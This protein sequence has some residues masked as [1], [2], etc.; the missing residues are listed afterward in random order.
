MLATSSLLRSPRRSIII[1][2]LCSL[3][4]WLLSSH[5]KGPS[6]HA[7]RLSA[8]EGHIYTSE[9]VTQLCAAH[10]F[11]PA[12]VFATSGSSGQQNPQK[13][14]VY[15]L[16][17]LS[18]E[19]DWL[20]IRLN[21]LYPYVDYF[22][23]LE[24][25]HTSTGQPKPLHLRENWSR[26]E[27]FHRKLIYVAVEGDSSS[28]RG[29]WDTEN[30]FRD[31]LLYETMERVRGKEKEFRY[32]D[33]LIV[34][35][36]DELPRPETVKLLRYCDFPD[37]LTLRSHFYS[38]SFQWLHRGEQW[39]HP[40]ATV[41]R[42]LS[43]SI[44]PTDLRYGDGGP[45]L[46]STLGWGRQT[47]DLLDTGWHCSFCFRTIKEMQAKM[48]SPSCTQW[49][50]EENRDPQMIIDRVRSGLDLF[51]RE[52]EIYDKIDGNPDVPPFIIEQWQSYRY[53]LNRDGEDA[54]FED[55]KGLI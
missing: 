44:P 47:A 53:L 15:D 46:R 42:G 22:V 12:P 48:Q 25:K 35:D 45:G 20:E 30:G 7:L 50:T 41:Y 55:V 36:I 4:L 17:V 8:F 40:Q 31:A 14:R 51:D 26:F 18:T 3:F 1:F 27:T 49:N 37:R 6:R 33:A 11:A 2:L 19:L 34:G 52:D 54:A 38:Y 5:R 21:T 32:G 13:R 24:S 43:N 10:N 39:A 29:S 23:I 16:F 28:I 9:D